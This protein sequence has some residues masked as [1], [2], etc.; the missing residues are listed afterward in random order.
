MP[1][2]PRF[3]SR[4]QAALYLGVSVKVFDAEV[5]K[6]MWPPARPRGAKGAKLTWDRVALDRCADGED[7]GGDEDAEF[8]RAR[9]AAAAARAALRERSQRP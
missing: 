5:E 4:E 7:Q 9:E 1:Y 3:L 8:E 6:G 2:W